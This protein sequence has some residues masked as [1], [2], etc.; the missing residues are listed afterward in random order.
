MADASPFPVPEFLGSTGQCR[1]VLPLQS[2]Y[3]KS[4]KFA[5]ANYF[6]CKSYGE[7]ADMFEF[8]VLIVQDLFFF[9]HF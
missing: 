7:N 5:S 1:P 2:V 4:R 8:Y 6:L 3:R 9:L